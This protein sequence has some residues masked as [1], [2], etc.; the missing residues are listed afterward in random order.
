MNK[1]HHFALALVLLVLL[2]FLPNVPAIAGEEDAPA[3]D[4][5]AASR[6]GRT[7]L[8]EVWIGP[9]LELEDLRGQVVLLE[10]WGF[11]CP[12]CVASIPHMSRLSKKH[13]RRGLV[14]IGTH[15]QGPKKFEALSAAIPKGVNYR[16]TSRANVPDANFSGIPHV[17]VFNHQGK[18]VYEGSPDNKMDK[19]I[20]AALKVRPHPLLGDMKYKKLAAA[21]SKAKSGKLGEAYKK[22]KED[23]DADSQ[24]GKEAAYLFANLERYAELLKKKAENTEESPAAAVEALKKLE[25][26]FAGT[27]Y[28]EKAAAKLEELAEDKEFQT[29]LKADKLYLAIAKASW[30]VAPLPKGKAKRA[31]WSRKFAKKFKA[32]KARVR[33]LKKKY[34]DTAA[35]QKAETLLNELV[36]A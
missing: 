35:A 26:T 30:S 17:F 21:A 2:V 34:P 1:M 6:L 22:C 36:G 31:K 25:K 9:P 10:F 19:A 11:R 3:K 27:E 18:V 15:A 23:K 5:W 28:G 4:D 13:G 33:K 8:G 29:E 20:V 24:L 32:V 16:I 12:P 14:V 7:T